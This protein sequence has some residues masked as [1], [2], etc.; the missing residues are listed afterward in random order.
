MIL[1]LLKQQ[2]LTEKMCTVSFYKDDDK[3]VI[4]SNRDEHQNRP[5]AIPP[6]KI[7][8]SI[9]A[10]YYPIDPQSNGTWFLVNTNVFVLL[11]GAAVKHTPQLPYRKSRGL[12]L[13]EIAS[14]ED[15]IEYWRKIDLT[16]IE[17]FTLIAYGKEGLS[18]FRWDGQAK[19]HVFLDDDK[20]HIWS[21][22]TLYEEEVIKKR[23]Q[24]YSDFLKTNQDEVSSEKL[25]HFHSATQRED[26]ENGLVIRRASKMLTK[27]ITQVTL[28]QEY[29]ILQHHDL[30][31]NEITTIQENRL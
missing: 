12:V 27:N 17:N 15:Y 21:S 31:K 29:F 23:A 22:S 4:T 25:I 2:F 26:H 8:G 1:G 16:S 6:Q 5:L 7:E 9:T 19:S 24:W 10:M 30:V 14:A 3:V 13:L 18:Q 20:P 28:F 11:N